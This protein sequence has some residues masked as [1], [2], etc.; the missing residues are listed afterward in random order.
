MSF[1]RAYN[2]DL[3]SASIFINSRQAS[4]F[5]FPDGSYGMEG[6]NSYIINLFD[7]KKLF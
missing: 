3:T 6:F 4:L 2:E 7:S 5:V 1:L